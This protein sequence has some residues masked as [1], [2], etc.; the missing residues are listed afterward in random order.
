M[1]VDIREETNADRNA[2]YE[3]NAAAFPTEAEA[4][5]V[6]ALRVSADPFVSLVAEEDDE[7]IGNIVFT[8]VALASF[9]DLQLMGLAPMAVKPAR[10]R[11]GIGSRLVEAGLENLRTLGVGAV[12]VLGHADYYPRFGFRPASRW[13]IASEYDVPDDAFM[14]LELASG[15]L[16]GYQGTIRYHAAFAE[17]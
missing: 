16:D 8:P 3:I 5:L 1:S 13:G 4:K 17:A 2:I 11:S 6:D 9:G 10:Q 12:V 15:Y 7:I 14:L